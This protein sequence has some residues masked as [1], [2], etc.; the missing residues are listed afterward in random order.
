MR[1]G[2]GEAGALAMIEPPVR[3]GAGVMACAAFGLRAQP[4][5]MNLVLVAGFAGCR[6]FETLASRGV[7]GFALDARMRAGKR[8]MRLPCVIIA[9]TAPSDR[10][11]TISAWRIRAE[12]TLMNRIGMALFASGRRIGVNQR[13]M[14]SGASNR[15]MFADERKAGLLMVEGEV[16]APVNI[17]VAP[18]AAL[19]K[20]ALMWILLCVTGYAG[21]G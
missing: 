7:A 13:A 1:A 17:V 8:I 16:F 12:T 18:L 20:R 5:L 6:Q 4:A 19:S 3:P 21:Y 15:R 14:A 2:Q 11:M 9:P 10:R